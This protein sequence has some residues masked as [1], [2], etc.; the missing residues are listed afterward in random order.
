MS[1]SGEARRDPN[2]SAQ[3]IDVEERWKLYTLSGNFEAHSQDPR[4][5]QKTQEIWQAGLAGCDSE[6]QSWESW[7]GRVLGSERG[8][9]LW[10]KFTAHLHDQQVHHGDLP[11]DWAR[12]FKRSGTPANGRRSLAARMAGGQQG[13]DGC[14][15]LPPNHRCDSPLC[16]L[17]TNAL[18]A[19]V[20][21]IRQHWP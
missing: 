21:P 12:V 16:T 1:T 5:W 17:F 13:S 14:F 19:D 9:P 3:D 6:S 10:G 15:L 7:A 8:R 11:S 20:R 4:G 18:A 2:G